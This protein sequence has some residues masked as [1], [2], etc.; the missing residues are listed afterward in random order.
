MY[1]FMLT[2][3]VN[4]LILCILYNEVHYVYKLRNK[5]SSL[6]EMILQA[7]EKCPEG[8]LV[9]SKSLVRLQFTSRNPYSH[10]AINFS[11]RIPVQ[12]KI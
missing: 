10:A 3:F 8:T 12:Y 9:Q 7:S 11:G 5:N 4:Y 2:I 1:D 6:N